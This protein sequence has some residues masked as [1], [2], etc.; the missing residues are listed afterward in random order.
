[1]RYHLRNLILCTRPGTGKA[2]STPEPAE[3]G[4]GAARTAGSSKTSSGQSGFEADR[5]ASAFAALRLGLALA[6]AASFVA[7]IVVARHWP[8]AGDALLTHY[9]AFLLDH[10]FAP[11]RQIID[12]NMPGCIL[13]D[14]TVIH[15]LGG[16][17]V[18]WRITD[19]ALLVLA[20]LAM[21]DLARPRV[22]IGGL[23]G[24]ALFAVVHVRDG[25]D[26][27]GE[28]DLI[29][30]VLLL[31]AC[32]CAV[33]AVRGNRRAA[34]LCGI[35]AGAALLI[36]PTAIVWFLGLLVLGA[37]ALRGKTARMRSLGAVLLGF[38]IAPLA[39]LIFLARHHAVRAFIDTV[40]GLMAYHAGVDR[41]PLFALLTHAIPSFL[42]PVVLGWLLLLVLARDWKS[43]ERKLILFSILF[44]IFSFVVQ[45]KG[46]PYQRYPAEAFLLLAVGI[47]GLAALRERGARRLIATA[48]MAYALLVAAPLSLLKASHY[49]GQNQDFSRSLSADLQALGGP[50]LSGHIQCMDTFGGCLGTLYQMR[51]LPATGFFYDC[52][53]F[54]QPQAPVTTAMRQQFLSEMEV[55]QPRVI[56]VTDQFCFEPTTGYGK[57][58]AWPGFQNWLQTHYALDVQRQPTREVAW[59]AHPRTGIGYRIYLRRPSLVPASLTAGHSSR[60]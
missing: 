10:G 8:L 15:L 59:W 27:A 1:M 47:D 23:V 41:L 57:L 5:T 12:M 34:F 38:L 9:A 55:R 26:Q 4:L 35:A 29:L 44:G 31:I 39:A 20:A 7:A 50:Q 53:F 28:R 32:A 49:D 48:V 11:Y 42:V 40:T 19:D 51:L 30:A 60:E 33:R 43:F 24:A 22:W 21:I 6:A 13:F 58:D 25:I 16:G 45:A 36:K 18:A 3:Q 37:F 14:W 17:S 56:V 54:H 46:F 2:R 52:Y